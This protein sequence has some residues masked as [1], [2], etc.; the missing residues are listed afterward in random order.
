MFKEVAMFYAKNLPHWERVL[1]VLLAVAATGYTVVNWSHSGWA[2]AAG[3]TA[4]T[5]ALT[6]L[7]GFCPMCALAGRKPVNKG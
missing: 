7:V 2:V 5:L 3:L 6:G 4:I 1:R